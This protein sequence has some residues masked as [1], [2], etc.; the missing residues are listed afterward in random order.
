MILGGGPG[1]DPRSLIGPVIFLSLLAS[2]ALGWIFNG[3]LFL[4]VLPLFVGPLF[5][6][7]IESNL[8]TGACPECGSEVQVLKGQQ[9]ACMVCGATMGSELSRGVF[10]RTGAVSRDDGVVEIEVLTDDD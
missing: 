5:S 6:W 10:M 1:F 7:Y 2:G 3:L 4:S 8:M 9:G